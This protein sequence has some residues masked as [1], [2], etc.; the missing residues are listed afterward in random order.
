MDGA[1][2]P[3]SVDGG[4]TGWG[5]R[6]GLRIGD[7]RG[8]GG[9]GQGASSWGALSRGADGGAPARV[10]Q[11]GGG[12][13]QG[14]PTGG[15]QPGPRPRSTN[16]GRRG[17]GSA[18]Q[19]GGTGLGTWTGDVA[20]VFCP[21]LPLTSCL[22]PGRIWP[23]RGSPCCLPGIRPGRR[24]PP[25]PAICLSSSPFCSHLRVRMEGASWGYFN[26]LGGRRDG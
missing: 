15:H 22:S 14:G 25:K 26:F 16:R 18:L 17:S 23:S 11:R 12:S 3:R 19:A 10:R 6:S 8:G 21:T 4:H 20:L 2:R 7:A 13:T 5:C 9:A 24:G 1:H